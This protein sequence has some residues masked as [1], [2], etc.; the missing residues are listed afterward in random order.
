MRMKTIRISM[1]EDDGMVLLEIHV[2]SPEQLLEADSSAPPAYRN[3]TEPAEETI[4]GYMDEYS[5]KKPMELVVVIPQS[6]ATTA[7]RNMLPD[8]VHHHFAERI[9]DLD[10]EIRLARREGIESL[11]IAII[12]A[13]VAVLFFAFF[14]PV[15]G[16]TL[17]V[18]LGVGL[19]TI[20]NWVTIWHTFEFFA[21]DW[22]NLLRKRKIYEKAATIPVRIVEEQAS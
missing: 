18:T 13:I 15:T 3:L 20:L 14:L 7:L 11:L 1:A 8:A 2:L 22:R 21:Y 16:S 19:I 9:P 17:A 12:N 5:V 10:H 6:L 4:A